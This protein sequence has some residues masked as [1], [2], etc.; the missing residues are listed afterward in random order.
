MNDV[1]VKLRVLIVDDESLGRDNVRIALQSDPDVE[2]LGECECGAEAIEKIQA[3]DPDLVFL[4]IQLPGGDAFA[5]IE[6]VGAD[7]MPLTVFVTAFDSHAVQAFE[8]HA[9]DYVLKPF[10]EVRLR[11]AVERAR[12]QVESRDARALAQRLTALVAEL[13]PGVPDD[14]I[15][16]AR[17]PNSGTPYVTRLAVKDDE[18][19]YLIRTTDVDWFEADGNYVRVHVRDKCY[20][21]RITVRELMAQLDPVRFRRIHRASVVNVDRIREVQ[22]WFG[23]D[24]LAILNE[25]TQLR[26]SRTYAS[27]LLQ[28][29]Q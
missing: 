21:L 10:D 22:P 20:R 1:R 5:V 3:L 23:G 24:Y 18:R 25:N 16:A 14:S 28:P 26:V 15:S 12:R 2:I 8:V 11:D 13:R 7:N 17:P 19:I 27:S 6:Q 4:D 29:L 9:L